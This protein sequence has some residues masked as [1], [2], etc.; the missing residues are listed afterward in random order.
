[1]L[2]IGLG[3]LKINISIRTLLD[4]I[5][6]NYINHNY[7]QRKL[8]QNFQSD[9]EIRRYHRDNYNPYFE[10]KQTTQCPKEKVQTHQ[11]KTI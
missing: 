11:K 5:I 8:Y 2:A 1:V 9:L 4:D 3:D 7:G 6:G 10:V